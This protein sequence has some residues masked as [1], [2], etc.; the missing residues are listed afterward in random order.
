M[1]L[2]FALYSSR[3]IAMLRNCRS[4]RPSVYPNRDF[5]FRIL[6]QSRTD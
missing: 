5:Y 4:I 6:I 2:L 1:Q 3:H